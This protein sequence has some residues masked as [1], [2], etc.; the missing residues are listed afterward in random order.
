MNLE[1]PSP[2]RRR[3]VRIFIGLLTLLWL[4]QVAAGL[5]GYRLIKPNLEKAE[6]RSTYGQPYTHK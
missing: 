6:D 2:W 1:T 3:P 5:A 4:V